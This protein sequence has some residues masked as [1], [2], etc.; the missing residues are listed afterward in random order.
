MHRGL[1]ADADGERPQTPK[2]RS[3]RPGASDSDSCQRAG[4]LSGVV[5]TTAR[6][7]PATLTNT[8]ESATRIPWHLDS[9]SG[10]HARSVVLEDLL[11]D[12]VPGDPVIVYSRRVTVT[13]A[14]PG[15]ASRSRLKDSISARRGRGTRS[16]RHAPDR[17]LK[18][19]FACAAARWLRQP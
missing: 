4:T 3:A 7:I 16:R 18:A 8:Q 10:G 14:P 11:S 6:C 2:P 5:I 15:A 17:R 19:A 1:L 9:T 13:R 12:G